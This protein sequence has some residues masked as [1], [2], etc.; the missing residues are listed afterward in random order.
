MDDTEEVLETLPYGGGTHD[1][2]P[3]KQRW[4]GFSRFI[5]GKISKL[6]SMIQESESC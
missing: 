6:E 4:V 5:S 1:L 3:D 2:R